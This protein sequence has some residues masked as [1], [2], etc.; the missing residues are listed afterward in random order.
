MNYSATTT[1]EL[2]GVL[3]NGPSYSTLN[4]GAI[5]FDGIDD[6]VN[7][8]TDLQ[9]F[10]TGRTPYTVE[11]WSKWNP[12]SSYRMIASNEASIGV[13]RDGVCLTLLSA[14]TIN[15]RVYHERFGSNN[16]VAPSLS[17]PLTTVSNS[18]FQTVATYDGTSVRVYV[19]GSGSTLSTST[20]DITNTTTSFRLGSRGSGSGN[21]FNGDIYV[22]RIYNRALSDSEILQNFNTQKSRFGL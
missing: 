19:N 16:Q 1:S 2:D 20:V 7:C 8:S 6:N 12:Q 22:G 13:G 11:V 15:A 18:P 10:F 21:F 4:G 3:T 14:D 5:A 17:V 9:Q